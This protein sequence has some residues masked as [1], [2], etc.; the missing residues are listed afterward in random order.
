MH[1]RM[2]Y[3]TTSTTSGFIDLD[4]TAD[5]IAKIKIQIS[6]DHPAVM[7]WMQYAPQHTIPLP[8]RAF[9]KFWD[10]DGVN[11]FSPGLQ[12]A[13][14]PLFEGWIEKVSPGDKT[15]NVMYTAMDPSRIANEITI[16]NL[17]WLSA[18][19]EWPGAVPRTVYNCTIDNDDDYAFSIKLNANMG[20][21]IA[22]LLDKQK[23]PLRQCG[24]APQTGLPYAGSDLAS[25]QFKPQEKFV[26]QGETLRNAFEQMLH[27]WEPAWRML[28]Y[29]GTRQWRFGDVT[30]CPEQTLTCNDFSNGSIHVMSL[31][32]DRSMD[33]RATA[34][35][36][37]GPPVLQECNAQWSTG[38]LTLIPVTDVSLQNNI[39]S[40]CNVPAYNCWQITDP[41]LRVV[42]RRLQLPIYAQYSDYYYETTN[43]PTFFVYY[44]NNTKAGNAGWRAITGWILDAYNGLI[45]FGSNYVFRYNSDPDPGAP[46]YEVPT[47]A[48]FTYATA[49]DPIKVRYPASGF[50]GTAYTVHGMQ[51]ER[52]M[53]DEMLAVGYEYNQPV[54]TDIRVNEF[55]TLAQRYLTQ[56]K[57]AVYTGTCVL[58]GMQYSFAALNRLINFTNK[59]PDGGPSTTGLESIKAFLT[60]AEYDFENSLTTLQFSS[61]QAQLIG[62]D[63][64][65]QKQKLK[66]RALKRV[67]WTQVSF[68]TTFR[69]RRIGDPAGGFSSMTPVQETTIS[70][71]TGHEYIDPVTGQ[72][73]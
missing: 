34:I 16:M 10:D 50:L 22:D 9:V 7:T 24:A 43:S 61:D 32:F 47:D 19:E 23:F 4:F 46:N 6:Y 36:I 64:S 38:G 1:L 70:I 52:K 37:Y 45:S 14:H 28:W 2:Q 18:F 40:C 55:A 11:P 66:I 71:E 56:S 67:D 65:V 60:D 63:P 30:Q 62:I 29:P 72:R 48:L 54:T 27:E 31:H 49:G 42:A 33:D 5:A 59:T 51:Y 13:T 12:T 73:G 25:L 20:Q 15:N 58:E 39:G 68:G 35:K 57:D 53:Y 8:I 21:I 17:G 3:S 26:L 44:P 41:L 69:E